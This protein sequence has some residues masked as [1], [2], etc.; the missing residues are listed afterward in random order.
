MRVPHPET[1]IEWSEND[2]E[3]ATKVGFAWDLTLPQLQ[4]YKRSK[5]YDKEI[6]EELETML[7]AQ[8]KDKIDEMKASLGGA[9]ATKEWATRELD[10]FEMSQMDHVGVTG[11][12]HALRMVTVF[13]RADLDNEI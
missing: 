10:E 3:E 12:P 8:T 7:K 9:E 2:T 13:A 6:A 1:D 4:E 5:F 11:T